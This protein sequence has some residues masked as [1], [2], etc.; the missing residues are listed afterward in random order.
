V[1]HSDC[2]NESLGELVYFRIEV[3]EKYFRDPKYLV[4]YTDYRGSIV[5]S[6]EYCDSD[7]ENEFEYI[8][9]FGLAYSK[10][11]KTKRTIVL[12]KDDFMEMPKKIQGYWYSYLL[13]N[14][15]EY[16][17]NYG[18]YKNLILGEWLDC[19]SIYNALLMEMYYINRMC[20]AI[21][22]PLMFMTEYKFDNSSLNKRPIRYHNILLPTKENYYNFIITLEKITTSNINIKT[23][24][25]SSPKVEN[26]ERIGNEGSVTMLKKWLEKN[27]K[28]NP[29]LNNIIIKPLK[30]LVKLRQ[31]PAHEI[32]DN[33]YDESICEEQNEL[34]KEVSSKYFFA[35]L[36][37]TMSD[38][39]EL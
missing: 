36:C 19:I 6:D 13:D 4:H 12:F 10:K 33:K 17:P 14:Q 26:I 22:I 1:K 24:T 35:A 16:F 8:K 3:L 28:G 29:S 31:T 39:L 9:N 2:F 34:I 38:S 23:F 32:Y 27:I 20:E 21:S 18:F 7:D 15:S 37:K 5:I 11:D 30:K 25:Y